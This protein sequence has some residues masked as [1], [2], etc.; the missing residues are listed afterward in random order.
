MES[1]MV[2]HKHVVNSTIQYCYRN[3]LWT[4][5]GSSFL[6]R[7]QFG[8]GQGED[9]RVPTVQWSTYSTAPVLRL[10]LALAPPLGQRP[11]A[12]YREAGIDVHAASGGTTVRWARWRR[13]EMADAEV[14]IEMSIEM[15]VHRDIR[16][17]TCQ[18]GDVDIEALES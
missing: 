13:V 18:V 12:R 4:V 1:S 8:L 15:D 3:S 2:S 6:V 11:D 7:R 9:G 14:Y 10:A 5:H 16:S 17:K